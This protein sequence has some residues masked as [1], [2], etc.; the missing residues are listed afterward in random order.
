VVARNAEV[1]TNTGAD[2]VI[3]GDAGWQSGALWER[4][5]FV[6]LNW[7]QQ[8]NPL[9]FTSQL[10]MDGNDFRGLGV[11]IRNGVSTNLLQRATYDTWSTHYEGNG[12]DDDGRYGVDQGINQMDDNNNGFVDEPEEGETRPPY[13]TRL[14]AIEV[15]MRCYE[16]ASRQIRQVTV[17]HAM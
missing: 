2:A 9:P 3:P 1:R 7:G 14:W 17:R 6:D 4:G 13:P 8:T 15:R 10:L 11:A 12:L 5:A 16:P